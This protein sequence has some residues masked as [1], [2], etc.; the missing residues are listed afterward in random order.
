MAGSL[1]KIIFKELQQINKKSLFDDT[2][3]CEPYEEDNPLKIRV[4][5]TPQD[6]LYAGGKFEFLMDVP[7]GYPN[8]PPKVSCKTKIYHPN[9]RYVESKELND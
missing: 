1:A 8:K 6:G 2:A 4:T 9:I 5:L 7:E 3:L